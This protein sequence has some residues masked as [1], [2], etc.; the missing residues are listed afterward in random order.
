VDITVVIPTIYP[1]S[2]LLER[3]LRS[4]EAQTYRA[5]CVLVEVDTDREGP[6]AVRNR[7]LEKVT[8]DWVAFLDDDDEL[9]PNHL[10]LLA[11]FVWATEVDVAYPGY[12]CTGQDKVNCF[13]VPFNAEFLRQTNYIP[14][15]VLARTDKIRASG[16]LP[17]PP[18]RERGSVRGLGTV[19]GHGRPGREVRPPASQDVAVAQRRRNHPGKTRPLVIPLVNSRKECP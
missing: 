7:A 16:R 4:V 18:G 11:R 3:A 8:T 5:A 14:V 12:D 6:A 17:T 19:A 13:G 2:H 15:T 10:K 1:R 9:Y